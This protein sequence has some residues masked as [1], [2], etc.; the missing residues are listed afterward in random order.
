MDDFVTVIESSPGSCAAVS[1]YIKSDV[2]V[3]FSFWKTA[4]IGIREDHTHSGR[5]VTRDL[6]WAIELEDM[7]ALCLEYLKARGYDC[8]RKD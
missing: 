5:K 3:T 7:D 6:I 2:S 8:I 1:G 4:S